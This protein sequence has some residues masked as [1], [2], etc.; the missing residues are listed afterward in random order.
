MPYY[1]CF[2]KLNLLLVSLND[3]HMGII[4]EQADS[5]TISK[6]KLP[7][8]GIDLDSLVNALVTTPDEAV[9]G[10]YHRS[11]D[12]SIAVYK[13]NA[14][15]V[16]NAVVLNS[17]SENWKKGSIIYKYYELPNGY[18]KVI[19]AQ[20][21]SL[22]MISYYDQI[23]KGFIKRSGLIKDTLSPF[24][25][26]VP[27]PEDTYLFKEIDNNIDYIKVGSFSSYYP[28]LS[29]AEDFYKSLENKVF[30]EH[31]IIDLRNNGGGGDRNSD[32][33]FKKLKKHLKSKKYIHVIT[34]ASTGSNAEQFTVKLKEYDTVLTY[35]D[36]TRGALSYEL[37]SDYYNLPATGFIAVLTSKLHKKFLPYETNGVVPDYGLKYNESWIE[38]I[39]TIIL[40]QL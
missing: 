6:M 40:D 21:P 27:Y 25:Y 31:L 32:I 12:L 33:L 18:F 24:F 16:Y 13:S 5:T 23:E 1:D 26:R 37:G 9:E 4:E 29:Y 14:K 39:K 3:W 30:K 38:Q 2:K 8:T 22:R 19:G 17:A 35:G 15:G 36:K 20:F 28:T 7:Q 10:I 11:S 34:N